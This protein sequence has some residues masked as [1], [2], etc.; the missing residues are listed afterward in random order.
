M[1]R[2]LVTTARLTSNVRRPPC[3]VGGGQVSSRG[4]RKIKWCRGKT[5]RAEENGA[6]LVALNECLNARLIT[7]SGILA[8]DGRS[9][10]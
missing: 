6:Y 4:W 9:W 10:S 2:V 8:D 5:I 3:T 7:T 1:L